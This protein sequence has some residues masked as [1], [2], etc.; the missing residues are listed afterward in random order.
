MSLTDRDR[1]VVMVVIPLV[2]LLGYWFLLFSPKR[3]EAATAGQ[4]LTK[5]QDAR[6]QARDQL[7][8]LQAAKTSFAADYSQLVQLGK[9]IPSSV[10]MPSLLV[11]LD[12]AAR[13]TGIKFTKIAHGERQSATPAASGSGA[14]GSAG[15]SDSG[16]A[17]SGSAQAT[18]AS[19]S[20]STPAAAPGGASAGTGPGQ[21]TETAGNT[22][23]TASAKSNA[24]A[25]T[26]G[27][28]PQDTQTSQSARDG[29]LPV[30]GAAGSAQSGTSGASGTCAPGLECIPLEFEFDGRFFPLADFFH[31]L[32]R[33]VEVVNDNVLV[34]GRLLTIDGMKFSSGSVFPKLKAEISA[35]VYLAPKAQGVTAGATAQGPNGTTPT[36][37]GTA[38][39]ASQPGAATG[40]SPT[41]PTATP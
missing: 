38:G 25:S 41:T 27:V 23:N 35:T 5:Q 19:G 1:K 29:K 12:K 24:S 10:D 39:T 20:G 4:E 9:A 11:Q 28:S 18:P 32:K 22:A 6:D 17:G 33:F 16:S 26:D 37:G 21:A 8:R 14:S 30:G 13:G 40:A 2:L 36:S 7:A 3:E 15:G 31:R 34:R